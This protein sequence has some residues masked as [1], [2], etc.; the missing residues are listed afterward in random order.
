MSEGKQRADW[1]LQSQ[2]C[3]VVHNSAPSF[4]KHKRRLV[5]PEEFNP[6]E[7]VKHERRIP[8]TQLLDQM[9]G[10]RRK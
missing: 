5:K 6:Y 2:L 10:P 8:F 1:T 4:G 3:A 7:V 9:F